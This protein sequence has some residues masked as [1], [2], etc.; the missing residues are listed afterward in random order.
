MSL[1]V[2]NKGLAL[3]SNPNEVSNTGGSRRLK[4]ALLA[5]LGFAALL[6]LFLPGFPTPFGSSNSLVSVSSQKD[7]IP[8]CPQSSLLSP[9]SDEHLDSNLEY[10]GSPSFIQKSARLLSGL[11]Q[12]PSESYDDEGPVGVD[13]RWDVFYKMSSYLETSFPLVHSNL[14]RRKINTHGLLYKWQGSD[15]SL[16]PMLLMAH[17]DVVPVDPSTEDEWKYPPYSGHFD[18]EMVWGRGACDCKT[19]LVQSLQ[20]VEEL[21]AKGFKPERT[22]LL[23]YGFDEESKG[24]EVSPSQAMRICCGIGSGR[25]FGRYRARAIWLQLSRT[26]SER[27][28]STPSWMK[29]VGSPTFMEPRWR[30]STPPRRGIWT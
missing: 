30:S 5:S 7:S 11:V 18:G 24:Y 2:S 3:G 25:W 21:L 16:K 27:T 19:T 23:S 26:S 4:S 17:Q 20:A 9:P 6:T 10:F 28:A 13:S 15:T 1:P 29:A 12:I 22:L 8:S 14:E